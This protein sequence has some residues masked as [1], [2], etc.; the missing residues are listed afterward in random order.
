[1]PQ[2]KSRPK[3]SPLEEERKL[4]GLGST[5]AGGQSWSCAHEA[6]FKSKLGSIIFLVI[7]RMV[8]TFLGKTESVP[9]ISRRDLGDSD[10]AGREED[11]DMEDEEQK[12]WLPTAPSHRLGR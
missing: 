9:S 3:I 12:G 4:H 10:V 1:M 2:I 5:F 8:V 11:E 6:V 7:W